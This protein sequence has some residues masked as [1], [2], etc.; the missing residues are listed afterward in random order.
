MVMAP[1]Q[2]MAVIRKVLHQ[3]YASAATLIFNEDHLTQVASIEA[4]KGLALAFLCEKYNID[5]AHTLA[6]G[7]GPN[8]CGMLRFAALGVAM[9]NATPEAQGAADV[10]APTNDEEGVA[11]TLHRYLL[12]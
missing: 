11:R 4:D 7:D 12:D 6:L 9:G 3:R 8:D 2:R 10:I 5:S 1:P